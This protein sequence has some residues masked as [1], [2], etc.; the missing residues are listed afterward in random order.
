MRIKSILGL[1]V[2]LLN[3]QAAVANN[4]KNQTNPNPSIYNPNMLSK[5][6]PELLYSYIDFDFDSSEGENFN[7]FQG[8]SYLFAIGADHILLPQSLVA[9]LYVFKID[10]NVTSQFLI[11]PGT[12]TFTN[13]N[14]NNATLFGHV[15]KSFN[16]HF[17]IDLFAGYGQNALKSQTLLFAGTPS[18][19]MAFANYG[20]TDW[21]TGFN[22][23]Y[24][25]SWNKI[26]F[27]ANAGLLYA[28]VNSPLY[29]LTFQPVLTPQLV[30]P[31]YTKATYVTEVVE[32]GYR[33]NDRLLPFINAGL[34]Q[35][36][37]FNTNTVFG[38]NTIIGSL[39]QLN[40]DKSGYKVGG[41]LTY[42]HKDFTVRVEQK[43]YNADNTY[44][45][46]QTIATFECRF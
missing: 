24:K 29:G 22:A 28:Q 36:P 14:I 45:S 37:G 38:R 39:P 1:A 35:V 16:P 46:N 4:S 40:L 32:F 17:D 43:Y 11:N 10:T 20:N 31:G 18:A 33:L 41:G 27:K 6:S 44:T 9:G 2:L 34:I 30:A 5:V 7:R 21:F 8:S 15:R 3:V 13:Q 23:I 12:A 26:L 42:T 25:K 19:T